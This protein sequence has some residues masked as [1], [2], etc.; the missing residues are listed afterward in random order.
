[1]N[2]NPRIP[3]ILSYYFLTGKRHTKDFGKD[4]EMEDRAE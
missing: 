4:I 2:R 3:C 1:M